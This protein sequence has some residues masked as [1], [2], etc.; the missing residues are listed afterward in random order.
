MKPRLGRWLVPFVVLL[1]LCSSLI[2]ADTVPNRPTPASP[3]PAAKSAA[4]KSLAPILKPI[5]EPLRLKLLA[6][7][8]ASSLKDASVVEVLGQFADKESQAGRFSLGL[9]RTVQLLG[10]SELPAAETKIVS[11]LSANDSRT[12][13]LAADVASTTKREAA[14]DPLLKLAGRKDYPLHFGFRRGVIDA[15]ARYPQKPAIDFLV[16]TVSELKGQLKYEAARH[17]T[18]TTGQN[19][20]GHEAHWKSWWQENRDSFRFET[21][22]PV[23]SSPARASGSAA[24]STQLPWP[25]QVPEFYGVPIYAQRICFVIDRSKSMASTVDGETRLDR[26]LQELEQAISGLPDYAYFNIVAF[27]TDITLFKRELIQATT[28]GKRQGIS[29]AVGLAPGELTN[30]HDALM[31]GLESDANLEAMLFLSD[32]EPTAGSIT[33]PFA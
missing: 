17:L 18:R 31:A 32:G 10:R 16:T 15:V 29:F 4:A 2:A 28:E 30:C 11:L 6:G 25:E 9:I 7:V 24:A 20:G 33:E 8:D 14:L 22:K 12:V 3:K 26:A 13:M 27:D 1:S 19:F 21:V 23:R 5:Q